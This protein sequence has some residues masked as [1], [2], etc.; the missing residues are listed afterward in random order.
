LLFAACVFADRP[1][2]AANIEAIHGKTYTLSGKHGPWMIMV[3]SL[4]GSTPEQEQQ[5]ARAADELVYQLRKKGVPAY[6]YKQD[7]QIEEFEGTDRAGRKRK[8]KVATQDG[9]IAVLAGNYHNTDDKVAKDTLKFIKKFN[10]KVSVD[11]QGKHADV[12]LVLTNA[13][14]TRNPL[15]SPE[16]LA[17]KQHDPLIVKLN[18]GID[19]SLLE[20][21]GKLTLIVASFYGKSQMRPKEFKDFDNMLKRDA[22]REN[23]SLEQAGRDSWTVMS[24]LRSKGYDAYVYHERFR[25]I[26]TVGAFKSANDPQIARLTYEFKAK[27]KLNP[28]TKQTGLFAEAINIPSKKKGEP[29]QMLMMD[30][31]PQLMEVPR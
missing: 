18:S 12:P 24:F 9:M 22:K 5:A 7:D 29:P 8:T 27:E 14:M 2:A 26:V 15:L 17:R 10:P 4:W 1:A 13:F 21:K 11:W 19:H 23:V 20:N 28:E 16:E 31:V 30:P 3:T 6:V 25:S